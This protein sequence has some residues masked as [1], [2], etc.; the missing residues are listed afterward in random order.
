MQCRVHMFICSYVRMVTCS[1]TGYDRYSTSII[2]NVTYSLA[3]RMKLDLSSWNNVKGVL[4]RCCA[5]STTTKLL[6]FLLLL[7]L[8]RVLLLL[9]SVTGMSC[10]K[11]CQKG[12]NTF[13]S[14]I[15]Y[16]RERSGKKLWDVDEANHQLFSGFYAVRF[17]LL[18]RCGSPNRTKPHHTYSMLALFK[19]APHRSL[20]FTISDDRTEPSRRV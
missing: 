7:S 20:A 3:G 5:C 17:F 19:T 2:L 11:K 16:H 10:T 15:Q 1:P 8:C 18:V 13:R 14:C 6:L 4:C 12:M 9:Q